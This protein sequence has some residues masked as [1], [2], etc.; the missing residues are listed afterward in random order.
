MI[1]AA[2][3]FPP[4]DAASLSRQDVE[5]MISRKMDIPNGYPWQYVDG[6]GSLVDFP[7][8]PPSYTLP[9]K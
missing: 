6:R 8:T 1:L 4:E 7:F 9:S 3:S 5:D 2:A